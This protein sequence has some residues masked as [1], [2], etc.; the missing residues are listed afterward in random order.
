MRALL[1]MGDR[2]ELT[3]TS[4]Y[5]LAITKDDLARY[6]VRVNSCSL[7]RGELNWPEP[8]EQAT[9][10]PGYDLAGTIRAYVHL[11]W[12]SITDIPN[13]QNPVLW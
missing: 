12:R 4:S 2:K 1:R 6:M 5:E 13:P 11:H 10:I 7:T 8:M 9:P 3:Y